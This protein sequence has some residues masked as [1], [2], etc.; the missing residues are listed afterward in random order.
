MY[1][2]FQTGEISAQPPCST[3]FSRSWSS[4]IRA[5]GWLAPKARQRAS[6]SCALKAATSISSTPL[7]KTGAGPRPRRR[8][9]FG[10]PSGGAP[11][12]VVAHGGQRMRPD[13]DVEQ[14]REVAAL[15]E[16]VGVEIEQPPVGAGE[17]RGQ[18][19]PQVGRLG[20]PRSPARAGRRRRR[21]RPGRGGRR[22]RRGPRPA[23]R[24]RAC[25][26]RCRSA[27]PA[28][29]PGSARRRR[30]RSAGSCRRRRRR[31]RR[32]RAARP[33]RPGRLPCRPPPPGLPVA[34]TRARSR[35]RAAVV[36]RRQACYG[37]PDPSI[38]LCRSP[39][40]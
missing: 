8:N 29:A 4:P 16:D 32:R 26:G 13:V 40:R 30:R 20:A 24:P 6:T 2:Q 34:S 33:R 5:G 38:S 9:D 39:R 21:C 15:H 22:G 19:Q 11:L 25:R 37:T 35:C 1:C 36:T 31:S 27:A 14:R 10:P 12:D 17:G 3:A 7:L 18:R 23:R 28:R